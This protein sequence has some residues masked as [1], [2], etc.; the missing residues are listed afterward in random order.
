MRVRVSRLARA[1]TDGIIDHCLRENPSSGSL[2]YAGPLGRAGLRVWPTGRFPYLIFYNAA[3][4]AVDVHRVIHGSRNITRV[5][6][7]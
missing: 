2:R 6:T 1:D 5:W 3:S 7:E 4:A